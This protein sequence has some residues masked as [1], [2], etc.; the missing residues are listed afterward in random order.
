MI[1]P[2]CAGDHTGL[3]HQGPSTHL[4][5]RTEGVVGFKVRSDRAGIVLFY[6]SSP[7]VLYS[8]NY[9]IYACRLECKGLRPTHFLKRIL[10]FK[11]YVLLGKNQEYEVMPTCDPREIY[12]GNLK[13]G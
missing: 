2:S 8:C 12:K 5:C 10:S 4:A 7:L 6:V 11:V 13:E 1:L 9:N 3:C